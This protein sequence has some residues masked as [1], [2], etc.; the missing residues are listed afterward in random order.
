MTTLKR[1][2]NWLTQ[3]KWKRDVKLAMADSYHINFYCGEWEK[4]KK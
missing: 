2:W 4:D 3:S 1:F